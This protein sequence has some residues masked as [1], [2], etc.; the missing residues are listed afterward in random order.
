MTTQPYTYN[1]SGHL[2]LVLLTA[3]FLSNCTKESQV[4]GVSHHTQD[5]WNAVDRESFN[6][7]KYNLAT[8]AIDCG[9]EINASNVFGETALHLATQKGNIDAVAFLLDERA[10]LS[11]KDFAGKTPL[12]YAAERKEGRQLISCALIRAG[13]AVDVVDDDGCAPL[14]HFVKN[15]QKNVLEYLLKDRFLSRH[16]KIDVDVKDSDGMTALHYAAKVGNKRVCSL[17]L[18]AGADGNAK[19]E[20]GMTAMHYAAK[21]E[22]YKMIYLLMDRGASVKKK[23]NKGKTALH[24]AAE[25]G[26]L[27]TIKELLT[28]EADVNAKDENGMTAMHYAAKH[29]D[30]KMIRRLMDRGASITEKDNKGKTALHYAAKEGNEMV[31]RELLRKKVSAWVNVKDTNGMTAL[32]YAS[33]EGHKDVV[34][35]LLNVKTRKKGCKVGQDGINIKNKDGMTAL[36]FAAKGGYRSIV[37]ELLSYEKCE[38]DLQDEYGWSALHHALGT[39]VDLGRDSVQLIRIGTKLKDYGADVNLKNN[40]GETPYDLRVQ[41]FQR[42]VDDGY[43]SYL[44][45]ER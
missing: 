4:L 32:H 24:Y 44:P 18:G 36:M 31:I 22:D 37:D 5:L 27:D 26:N 2:L 7:D 16:I 38:V 17:L 23:D 14:H 41:R 1:R 34:E 20:N 13:A 15:N 6:D 19:D 40:D 43:Y 39:V 12:H 30:Y 28:G 42:D 10:R 9:A 45:K 21:Y 8:T 33:R 29:K 35:L 11:T 25:E 3:V